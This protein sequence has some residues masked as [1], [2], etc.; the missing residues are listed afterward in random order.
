MA[1]DDIKSN[2]QSVQQTTFTT[3]T[4]PDAEALGMQ[5]LNK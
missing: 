2:V 3:A 1:T 4:Q 5:F